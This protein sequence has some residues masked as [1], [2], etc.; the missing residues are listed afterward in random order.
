MQNSINAIETSK[1][2]K[3]LFF[4][5]GSV[6]TV[7]QRKKKE[8]KRNRDTRLN[9]AVTILRRIVEDNDETSLTLLQKS[10]VV[11]DRDDVAWLHHEI[12]S[13]RK[14]R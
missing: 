3:S 9:V 1:T 8:K 7:M 12:D 4:L 10:V 6:V 2:R 5:T 11:V 14:S 13:Q